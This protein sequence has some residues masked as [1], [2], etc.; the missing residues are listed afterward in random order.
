MIITITVNFHYS[1]YSCLNMCCKTYVYSSF[2]RHY[3][4]FCPTVH[5]NH[6]TIECRAVVM[7]STSEESL[8]MN[9]FVLDYISTTLD[10]AKVIVIVLYILLYVYILCIIYTY[11]IANLYISPTSSMIPFSSPRPSAPGSS[12]PS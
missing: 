10:A 8:T 12:L 3:L 1:S 9:Q 7:F 2:F 6:L 4:Y 5:S 11:K